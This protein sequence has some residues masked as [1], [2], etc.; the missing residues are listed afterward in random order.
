MH[1]KRTFYKAPAVEHWAG[2]EKKFPQI[3]PQLKFRL[4]ISLEI[5]DMRITP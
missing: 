1:T 4:I 3:P 2:F 5:Q